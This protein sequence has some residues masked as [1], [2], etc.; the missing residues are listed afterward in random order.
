MNV[1][2]QLHR[3]CGYNTTI[4]T[5][6][7][8]LTIPHPTLKELPSSNFIKFD[9]MELQV[10]FA[11]FIFKDIQRSITSLYTVDTVS[12]AVDSG[13]WESQKEHESARSHSA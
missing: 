11:T 13:N 3:F 2:A 6:G 4:T 9:W 7:Y 5:L 8:S 10:I 1:C 12:K